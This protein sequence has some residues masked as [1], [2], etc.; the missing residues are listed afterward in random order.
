[1]R[2][3]LGL[4]SLVAMVIAAVLGAW[5]SFAAPARDFWVVGY[6]PEYRMRGITEEQLAGVTDVIYFS[7]RAGADGTLDLRGVSA[8]S[9]KKLRDL[10]NKLRF[11]LLLAVGGWGK[12]AGFA[13]ATESEKAPRKVRQVAC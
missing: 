2:A 9:L 8:Q 10:R 1:M 6:L 12:S 13:A 11:R 3:R 5:P 4:V 7:G